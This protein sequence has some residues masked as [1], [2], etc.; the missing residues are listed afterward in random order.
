MSKRPIVDPLAILTEPTA[1]DGID[2]EKFAPK[3]RPMDPEKAAAAL[4]VGASAGLRRHGGEG[5]GDLSPGPSVVENAP[6]AAPK[7]ASAAAP[8]VSVRE[9]KAAAK[10]Q[11]P[12]VQVS[13]RIRVGLYD[14]LDG[15][16]TRN[17]SSVAELLGIAIA[18]L[19]EMET[20][21]RLADALRT[22]D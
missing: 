13:A 15:L 8:S 4:A 12:I 17:R 21:G 10:P 3:R 1:T 2:L 7:A 18:Q 20:D 14:R 6:V 16:R 22:G 11:E 19:E 9:R 5:R